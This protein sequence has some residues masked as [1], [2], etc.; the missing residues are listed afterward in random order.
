MPSSQSASVS[1]GIG[2]PRSLIDMSLPPASVAGR[3]PVRPSSPQPSNPIPKHNQAHRM[4]QSYA[5]PAVGVKP[6]MH[7]YMCAPATSRLAPAAVPH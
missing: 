7:A 3:E 1:Q 4:K 2:A 5:G 6:E